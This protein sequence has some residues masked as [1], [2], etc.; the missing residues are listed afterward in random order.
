MNQ[1]QRNRV[2]TK[3]R[4]GSIEL[5]VATD[6][7]ARG[8][9]VDDIDMVFNF[10]VPK[11]NEDYVHR[12]GRTG[13][14][15]K[16]GKAYSFVLGKDIR[17]LGDIQ[18]YTKVN[19]KRMQVPSLADIENIKK[20]IISEKVKEVLKEKNLEKYVGMAK[21][22]IS[23]EITSLDVA[24]ALLKIM[25]ASEKRE[26]EQKTDILEN[27]NKHGMARLFINV[28]KKNDIRAGDFVG[29]IAGETGINSSLI[30]NIKILDA[31][32]FVEVPQEYAVDVINALH[33]S[34]IKGKKVFVELAKENE[35]AVGKIRQ[36]L[37]NF[38]KNK[39]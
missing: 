7:A 22:L 8:I 24:T 32:S 16:A 38:S 21:S 28:G 2:M 33:S 15:G 17:K 37:K 27:I 5:L 11:D 6:V 1:S 25:F 36:N 18:R 13:R 35:S 23:E 10:D 3:F 14:A 20:M 30:G 26:Q 9:D 12:I 4:N 29:A 31:F 34:N 19:I 39:R